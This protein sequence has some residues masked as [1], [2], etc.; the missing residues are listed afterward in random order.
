MVLRRY[1]LYDR[2]LLSDLSRCGWEALKLYFQ[3]SVKGNKAVPGACVAIQTFG[4]LLGFHP[5][6]HILVSDGCFQ[7]NSMFTRSKPIFRSQS[8][9]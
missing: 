1:F 7:E 3:K 8:V 6:L 5:H 4:D 9:D 2:K